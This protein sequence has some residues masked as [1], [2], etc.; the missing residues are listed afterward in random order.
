VSSKAAT[1]PA[2]AER[3]E[4]WLFSALLLSSLGVV[5]LNNPAITGTWQLALFAFAMVVGLRPTAAIPLRMAVPL[6]AASAMPVWGTVLMLLHRAAYPYASLV[7]TLQWAVLPAAMLLGMALF[8]SPTI[9]RLFFHAVA[10]CAIATTALELFQL[11]LYGRYRVTFSGLPLIS[12]NLYAELTELMLPIVL[13]TSLRKGEHLWRGCGLVAFMAGTTIAAGAR[14]GSALVLIEIAAVLLFTRRRRGYLQLSW[15]LH[16][17]PLL[18]MLVIAIGLEGSSLLSQKLF[19]D[20]MFEG[21]SEISISAEKMIAAHP[22]TGYGLGSF[23]VVYPK[24]ANFESTYFVNHVHDD[25]L[26]ILAET[27][28]V[29]LLLWGVTLAFALPAVLRAPWAFG[30]LAILIH[31]GTDFPLYRLPVV[32]LLAMVLAAAL[33]RISPKSENRKR[34]SLITH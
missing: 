12:S 22:I 17:I 24:Y 8:R 33:S 29:G 16:A 23:A 1:L 10:G 4:I 34:M 19:R 20:H 14:M 13:A 31:S 32:A 6:I 26:E 30:I 28:V 25:Y 11:Y 18:S 9:R 21:R 27:G 15:K 2:K 5:C 7:A 3:V